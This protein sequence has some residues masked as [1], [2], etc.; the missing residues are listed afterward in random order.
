MAVPQLGFYHTNQRPIPAIVYRE[1]D[2]NG[3]EL[4]ADDAVTVAE[5][6]DVVLVNFGSGTGPRRGVPVGTAANEFSYPA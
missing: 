5:T 2:A 6:V 3:A 4:A 1:Y